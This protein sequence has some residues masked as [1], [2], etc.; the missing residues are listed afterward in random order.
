M[1]EEA[2]RVVVVVQQVIRMPDVQPG[3]PDAN[4]NRNVTWCNRALHR[5]LV[6]LG[7]RAELILEPRGI[8]WTNA[9]AMVR[10][11]RANL[12]ERIAPAAAQERANAG[13]FIIAV[14]ENNQGPGHVEM[15]VYDTAPFNADR[16]P[17]M[18]GAGATNG[19]GH[20]VQRFGNRLF[21]TIEY[22]AVPPANSCS[23]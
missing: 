16:G 7:A 11:A 18:G 6:N 13:E 19:F 14:A 20:A 15:C 8:G 23:D 21:P 5:I 4:G 2:K 9:N 3:H 22:Y 17:K 1:N 12:G 10:N